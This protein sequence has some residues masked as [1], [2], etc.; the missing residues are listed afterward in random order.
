MQFEEAYNP[1]NAVVVESP[2]GGGVVGRS[3][4][5]RGPS[6]RASADRV[7]PFR[8]VARQDLIEKAA[9]SGDTQ[10]ALVATLSRL[11]EQLSEAAQRRQSER[12]RRAL[13]EQAAAA[14]SKPQLAPL[15]PVPVQVC[16]FV[17]VCACV[18]SRRPHHVCAWSVSYM[19]GPPAALPLQS[20]R[21][22]QVRM[23][24]SAPR[25]GGAD[26]PTLLAPPGTT[27]HSRMRNSGRERPQQAH[28]SPPQAASEEGFD[29]LG[30]SASHL[31]PALV[32][33]QRQRERVSSREAD[34]VRDD[35]ARH[36]ELLKQQ[37]G[38]SAVFPP[39]SRGNFAASALPQDRAEL[40]KELA[41]LEGEF[42]ALAAMQRH[43][44]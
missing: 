25:G 36:F 15:P 31:H 24:A 21:P 37:V 2:R 3:V 1:R 32:A 42:A 7:V 38:G 28:P 12:T 18:A 4:S 43:T 14:A 9:V 11:S 30:E 35:L 23:R 10:M 16:L 39:S 34:A 17:C 27:I 6:S 20:A 40:H 26:A 33:A 8:F 5:P 41:D 22:R 19:D 13:K 29:D 44:Q